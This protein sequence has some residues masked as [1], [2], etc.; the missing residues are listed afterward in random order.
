MTEVAPSPDPR[1]GLDRATL[2][3]LL[4]EHLLAG[5]LIDRAGM[6]LLLG[7]VGTDV[8]AQVAIEEWRGASPLYTRRMQRLLGF[9][10]DDV[11]TIFKGMQLD[12][13]APPQFLDFRYQVADRDHGEFWLDHCG[14]L[15]DV[16]PMGEEL[17]HAMCHDIEDPTFPATACATNP[18]ARVEPVHRPPRSPADRHPHC[19]WTVTI[20][21]SQP[22]EQ[23]PT[24]A[25]RLA[26]SQAAQVPLADPGEPS[27]D[28]ADGRRRY[29][30][31]L[32]DDVDLGGFAAPVQVAI[33]DEVCLQGHLLVVSFLAAAAE[34]VGGP[35]A[36]D[37][38]RGQ[39][40]GVGAVVAGRLR[41]ALDLGDGLDDV[42]TV[43]GLHPAFLPRAYVDLR[44]AL[45][46]DGGALRV[47]LHDGPALHEEL[48]PSWARLLAEAPEDSGP[49]DAIVQGVQPR[50]RCRPVPAQDRAEGVAA[51][52]DVVL[53]DEPAEEPSEVTLTRFSTGA[54]FRFAD[55]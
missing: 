5:H 48:A 30:G 11:A 54:T 19:R 9:E 12:V 31:P 13:G 46:P 33:D 7:H 29:D 55:R 49:L 24:E 43:L 3:T 52:W 1:V 14:A 42:A 8:M 4:R 41:D 15:M 18:H 51:A 21:S 25:V 50:A 22:A 34:R 44:V 23:E 36:A 53:V 6:P 2:A 32:E 39:L 17:V 38:G 37:L 16:E 27:G 35:A 47:E 45:A 28:P 20:D 10:G 26:R 40:T